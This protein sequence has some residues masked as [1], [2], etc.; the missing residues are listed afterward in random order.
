MLE[1]G[2]A[3]A[4][5]VG[6]VGGGAPGEHQRSEGAGQDCAGGEGGTGYDRRLREEAGSD[7][8]D[9]PTAGGHPAVPATKHTIVALLVSESTDFRAVEQWALRK[10]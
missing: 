6:R 10:R 4:A 1:I 2:V 5:A 3:D 8:P 7:A 9:L